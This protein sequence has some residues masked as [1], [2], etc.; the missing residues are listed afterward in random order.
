MD[1]DLS[2]HVSY[3][4]ATVWQLNLAAWPANCLVLRAA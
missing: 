2:H 3:A 4:A 1:A